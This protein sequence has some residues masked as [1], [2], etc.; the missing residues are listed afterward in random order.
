MGR[1]AALRPRRGLPA[2][3]QARRRDPAKLA[4]LPVG[5][6]GGA[7]ERLGY[8]PVLEVGDPA[9]PLWAGQ[10]ATAF[11][12]NWTVGTQRLP[13]RLRARAQ[14]LRGRVPQGG[15]RHARRR[16][17]PP[18]PGPPRSG[19]PLPRGRRRRAVRGRPARGRGGDREDPHPRVDS[20]APL[21][22]APRARALGRTG[23]ACSAGQ[24]LVQAALATVLRSPR[25]VRGREEGDGLVLGLCL[26]AGHLRARQPPLRR[27][28]PPARPDPAR[29]TSGA[30]RTRTTSTAGSTTSARRS[31]FPRSS[32]PCTG[33]T[34]CCRISSSTGSGTRSQRRP[35][36][37]SGRGHV[38]RPGDGGDARARPRELGP[39]AG[40]PARRP[41]HAGEPPPVPA[42]PRPA[43]RRE[44]DRPDR[45]RRARPHPGPRARRAALQRVPP[46]V[47]PA[48]ADELR[49]LRGPATPRRGARAGRAGTAG[50]D[51]PRGVRAAPVRRPEA[52]HRR[53]GERRR[54]ADRRLP[55]ASRRQPSWT[56]SRTSTPSS[57]GSPS[58]GGPTASPSP[59]RS[60]RCSS[61]TR[62]GGFSATASS[63]RASV[64]SSTVTSACDGSPTTGPT[65]RCWSGG[66][67]RPDGGG[68]AL[69]AGA[70]ADD[71]GARAG[72]RLRRERLRSLGARS[73][74]L[75]LPR[76]EASARRRGRRGVQ[77]TDVMT[78]PRHREMA[79]AGDVP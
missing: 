10:E 68:V 22:R 29:R 67:R 53:A 16:L 17:G 8:L 62:R 46:P 1:L 26:G 54:V 39:V 28:G 33:C 41:A 60:S 40:P 15:R 79:A 71:P 47:R 72:A 30:S 61:S 31:T 9:N 43:G 66:G 45:R 55:R 5:A 23:P 32:S 37:D 25:A 18:G 49:R 63:R 4:I 21:Q 24:E 51:P 77:V 6:R 59:R 13:H 58:S 7:G 76:V 78:W 11:P 70:P 20:P 73:R 75:L 52:H 14:P 48:T 50:P 44:P 12:D 38:P 2:A 3:R 64:P 27:R 36:P 35:A 74:R 42:E 19:P 56:T 57:A 65:A 34:P 69:E